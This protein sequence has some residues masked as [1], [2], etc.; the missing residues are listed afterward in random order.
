MFLLLGE[1]P[2]QKYF[3]LEKFGDTGDPMISKPYKCK[4]EF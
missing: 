2:S 1:K 4:S 3:K